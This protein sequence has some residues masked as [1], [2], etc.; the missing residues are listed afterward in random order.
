M[1]KTCSIAVLELSGGMLCAMNKNDGIINKT[2]N[3]TTSQNQPRENVLP[4]SSMKLPH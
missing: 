2:A 4:E 1:I 3:L